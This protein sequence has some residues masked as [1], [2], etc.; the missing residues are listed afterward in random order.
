LYQFLVGI[1]PFC[2]ESISEVFDNIANLRMEWPEIGTLRILKGF[3]MSSNRIWGRLHVA[4]SCRFD[5]EDTE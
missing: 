2:G 4:G 3:I 5:K 1:P